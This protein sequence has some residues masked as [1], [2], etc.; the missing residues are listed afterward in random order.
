MKAYI[1]ASGSLVSEKMSDG[2][3]LTLEENSS[4]LY[5]TPSS[6]VVFQGHGEGSHISSS[7]PPS[8]PPSPDLDSHLQAVF[9]S[10]DPCS[11]GL[12]PAGQL[13]DYLS[14]LVDQQDM[15]RWKVEE[16]SRMLDPVGNNKCVTSS[17]F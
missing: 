3:I 13:V 2:A 11:S 6:E 17:C 8:P 15:Q 10:C 7:S 1:I 5:L 14:S 16:L 12:V 9:S 4:L